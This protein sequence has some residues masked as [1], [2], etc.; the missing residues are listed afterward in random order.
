MAEM[1]RII[2]NDRVDAAL[3]ALFML[4]VLAMIGFG[5]RSALAGWR[6]PQPTARETAAATTTA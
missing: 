6:A 5:I 3:A 1:Q 4:V 2:V